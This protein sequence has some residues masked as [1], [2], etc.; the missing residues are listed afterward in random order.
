MERLRYD[1]NLLHEFL[2][3]DNEID[4][5][6]TGKRISRT[7]RILLN[8]DNE[9]CYNFTEYQIQKDRQGRIIPCVECGEIFCKHQIKKKTRSNI[10]EDQ[11]PVIFIK[12]MMLDKLEAI[13]RWSFGRSYQLR[14][15]DGLTFKFCYELS[16]KLHNSGK[17][18]LMAPIEEN[19]PQKI[20]LRNNTAPFYAW[21]EGRIK[22]D[23]YA[24]ILHRATLKIVD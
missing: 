21:L 9:L 4:L 3:N 17:M 1:E 16:Q 22:G 10:N 11:K 14:H 12:P 7:F 18:V 6:L 8:Q 23:K 24:L 13:K 15:V 19:K 20:I 5:E 2:E